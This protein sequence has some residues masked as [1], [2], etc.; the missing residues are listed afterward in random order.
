MAHCVPHQR[1][2]AQSLG[3]DNCAGR[4]VNAG[5]DEEED[6]IGRDKALGLEAW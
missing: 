6:E 2:G 3:V 5:D 1:L 4:V